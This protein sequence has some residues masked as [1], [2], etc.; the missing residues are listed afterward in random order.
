MARLGLRGNNLAGW[1]LNMGKTFDFSKF[2]KDAGFAKAD[3]VRAAIRD[4]K[5]EI[6]KLQRE[7]IAMPEPQRSQWAQKIN[8]AGREL[9]A[10]YETLRSQFQQ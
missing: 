1:K 7:T 4:K 8:R 9:D 5:A 2:A 10:L 3:D 6:E